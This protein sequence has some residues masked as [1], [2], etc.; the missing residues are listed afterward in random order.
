[1]SALTCH[2][3]VVGTLCGRRCRNRAQQPARVTLRNC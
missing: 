3:A 1:M 2:P